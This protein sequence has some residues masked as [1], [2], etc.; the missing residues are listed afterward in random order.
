MFPLKEGGIGKIGGCFKKGGTLIFMLTN[1][2]KTY[3]SL[4]E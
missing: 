1:P 4:S 2:F 3:L